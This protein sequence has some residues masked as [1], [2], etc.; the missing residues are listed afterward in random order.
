[1]LEHFTT[2]AFT[3]C[4]CLTLLVLFPLA[5]V[6]FLFGLGS[7]TGV[8]FPAERPLTAAEKAAL[9]AESDRLHR[10]VDA[11]LAKMGAERDKQ[12]AERAGKPKTAQE[13]KS[14]TPK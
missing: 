10:E 9:N 7:L 6:M 13:S 2:R 1:M 14:P 4:G 5:L 11:A 12:Q 8:K 3:P